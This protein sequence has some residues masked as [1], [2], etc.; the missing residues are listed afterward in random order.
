[1][2]YFVKCQLLFYV[3]HVLKQGIEIKLMLQEAKDILVHLTELVTKDKPAPARD[4]HLLPEDLIL[5][6][7]TQQE[8]LEL[9]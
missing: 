3:W 5:P 7:R 8:L 6:V 4:T 1:M 9:E 2:N